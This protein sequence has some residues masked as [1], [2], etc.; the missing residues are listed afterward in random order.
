VYPGGSFLPAER[1]P[2]KPCAPQTTTSGSRYVTM[3]NRRLTT[4][5]REVLG[6]ICTGMTQGEIAS[7]LR[8]SPKTVE[9]HMKNARCKLQARTVAQAV[10]EYVTRYKSEV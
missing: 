1:E 3:R 5:E 7:F 9:A 10:Y 6:A 2:V 4:R 8:L